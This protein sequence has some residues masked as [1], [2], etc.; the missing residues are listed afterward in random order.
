MLSRP[1]PSATTLLNRA[2]VVAAY[3]SWFELFNL[4]SGGES[5]DGSLVWMWIGTV[6]LLV[7]VFGVTGYLTWTVTLRRAELGSSQLTARGLVINAQLELIKT[8][9]RTAVLVTVFALDNAVHLSLSGAVWQWAY[10]GSVTLFAAAIVFGVQH[11]LVFISCCCITRCCCRC[12]C[13]QCCNAGSSHKV[14]EAAK[15]DTANT[16]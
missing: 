13:N 2:F 9:C 14:F 1:G 12:C 10:A 4:L 16:M 11:V 3:F 7:S 5:G 8:G 6:L 15:K